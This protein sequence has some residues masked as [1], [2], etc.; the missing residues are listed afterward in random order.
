M[1]LLNTSKRSSSLLAS[2][3]SE[4]SRFDFSVES[5]IDYA[6]CEVCVVDLLRPKVFM[7]A[8]GIFRVLAG[9]FSAKIV[10]KFIASMSNNVIVLPPND[11]WFN[12]VSEIENI[13]VERIN[14]HSMNH[15]NLN[16]E[17]LKL[18]AIPEH[19]EVKRIDLPSAILLSQSLAL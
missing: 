17:N 1:K 3:F 19:N 4:A 16:I 7:F 12:K 18:I 2:V 6:M 11:G 10:N 8:N 5:A 9:D 14:R 15:D 13:K